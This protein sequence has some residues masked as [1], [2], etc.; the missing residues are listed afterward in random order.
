[1]KKHLNKA[2]IAALALAAA[3][4]LGAPLPSGVASASGQLHVTLEGRLKLEAVKE[5]GT[6]RLLADWFKNLIT[7]QGLNR[8]GS[9]TWINSCQ[10][11]TGNTAPANTD[12]GLAAFVAGTATIQAQANGAN[13]SAP[14]YGFI[15]RTFRFA[16]GAA[17]GNLAEVG[18]GW[19]TTGANLFSRALIKDAGGTP[20]TV[21]VA[22]DEFLDVSYELRCYAPAETSVGPIT[23]SG[24][25]YT[26]TIRPSL[27]TN[28]SNWAPNVSQ[29]VQNP[30]SPC[31]GYNGAVGAVTAMPSGSA[32]V[33]TSVNVQAYSN[34]SLQRDF[35]IFFDLN[36]GNLAGG[37]SAMY[38][39]TTI[40][41]FQFG[42]A[43]AFDKTA[44]KLLTL[45]VRVSWARH[46]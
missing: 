39:A 8:M 18:I 36:T 22:A 27:V 16:Q 6:R 34:N 17:A 14:Y 21:T 24:T 15:T 9:N 13:G 46:V 23:I 25:N 2:A 31:L 43:P 4:A 29:A 19:A 26:F 41:A 32:A 10:V 30:V 12:T 33:A 40:G 1:M 11:G 3:Q 20:T 38:F 44:T 45:N 5:D 28:S 37:I 7:D 42:I 35:Q